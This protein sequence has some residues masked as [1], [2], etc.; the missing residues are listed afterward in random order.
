MRFKPITVLLFLMLG[1]KVYGQIQQQVHN[2]QQGFS[3]PFLSKIHVKVHHLPSLAAGTNKTHVN[4]EENKSSTLA[5]INS[6]EVVHI[7]TTES[8]DLETTETTTG[9]AEK[10]TNTTM[11]P[12]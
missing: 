9:A 7:E 1:I 6:T 2:I 4:E 5:S 11:K 8:V 3:V 10:S 12:L